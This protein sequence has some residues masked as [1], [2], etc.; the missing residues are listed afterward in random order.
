MNPLRARLA[1]LKIGEKI[2]VT[3]YA[4][5]SYLEQLRFQTEFRD[6]KFSKTTGYVLPNGT[7]YLCHGKQNMSIKE[8]HALHKTKFFLFT[9]VL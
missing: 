5:C 4:D 7:D 1:E 9:R 3:C 2:R 6:R 8:R